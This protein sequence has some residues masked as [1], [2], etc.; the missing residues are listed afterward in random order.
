[1]LAVTRGGEGEA[2]LIHHQRDLH[3]KDG[4]DGARGSTALSNGF[5]KGPRNTEERL[6]Y[7]S[8]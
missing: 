2:G 6:M 4:H 3:A 8:L 7:S 1:M 5:F